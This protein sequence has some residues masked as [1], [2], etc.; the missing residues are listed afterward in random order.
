MLF[1]WKANP[2][3]LSMQD[4]AP[5]HAALNTVEALQAEGIDSI[6][7]PPNLLTLIRYSASGIL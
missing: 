5:D 3:V 4:V 7:W 2:S 6:V 1:V